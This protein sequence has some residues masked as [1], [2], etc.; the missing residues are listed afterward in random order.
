M[1]IFLKNFR[2]NIIINHKFKDKIEKLL[3]DLIKKFKY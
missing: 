1:K 3:Y 2:M